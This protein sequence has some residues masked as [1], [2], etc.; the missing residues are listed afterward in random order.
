[1]FDSI[2]SRPAWEIFAFFAFGTVLA[3]TVCARGAL[4]LGADYPRRR[5]ILFG[6]EVGAALGLAVLACLW[7][8]TNPTFDEIDGAALSVGEKTRLAGFPTTLL[9]SSWLKDGCDWICGAAF[10]AQT[11]ALGAFWGAT[12][13]RR[14]VVWLEER[15]EIEKRQ[16]EK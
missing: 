12:G 14:F 8:S 11:T 4:R 1:M 3:A 6:S 10:V 2:W 9:V 5:P 7:A 16:S 13:L 15:S